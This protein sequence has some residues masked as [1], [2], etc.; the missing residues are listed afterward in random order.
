MISLKTVVT[1]LVSLIILTVL[2]V[3]NMVFRRD[4]GKGVISISRASIWD[5]VKVK[6]TK[7]D[8]KV[9]HLLSKDEELAILFNE[10]IMDDIPHYFYKNIAAESDLSAAES[11]LLLHELLKRCRKLQIE[12]HA[13]HQKERKEFFVKLGMINKGSGEKGDLALE[14]VDSLPVESALQR[15]SVRISSNK[16]EIKV[17]SKNSP[18]NE[19]II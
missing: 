13:Q 15:K 8:R 12:K 7:I 6:G 14:V 2:T 11:E 19:F 5:Y 9:D 17:F 18:S 10:G 16:P 4:D 1:F 3:Y